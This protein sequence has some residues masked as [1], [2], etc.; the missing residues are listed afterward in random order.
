MK[1]VIDFELVQSYSLLIH[2]LNLWLL[3]GCVKH[4]GQLG[5]ENRYYIMITV[6]VN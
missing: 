6:V 2:F 5:G 3:Y 1:I 4:T